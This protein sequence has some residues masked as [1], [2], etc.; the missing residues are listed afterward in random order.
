MEDVT[1]AF[2]GHAVDST[3]KL[4]NGAIQPKNF[5]G[6]FNTKNVKVTPIV[7]CVGVALDHAIYSNEQE[8]NSCKLLLLT[9]FD[10]M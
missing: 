7:I 2:V 1:K 6:V 4:V 3:W 5:H 8:L 10:V 9:M